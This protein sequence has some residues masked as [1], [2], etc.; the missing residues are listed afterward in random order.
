MCSLSWGRAERRLTRLVEKL[1]LR[2]VLFCH[3]LD[4]G[5]SGRH[6]NPLNLSDP[7]FPPFLFSTNISEHLPGVVSNGHAV[8]NNTDK[9]NVLVGGER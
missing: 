5:P 4:E 6:L 7:P 8:E 1:R 3:F 2:G 9:A